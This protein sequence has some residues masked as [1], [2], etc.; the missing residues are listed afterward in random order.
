MDRCKVV[1]DNTFSFSIGH[2]EILHALHQA[3]SSARHYIFIEMYLVERGRAFQWVYALLEEASNR[4]VQIF[5]LLDDF[6]SRAV[7]R[8]LFLSHALPANI[9]V[10]AY[11]PINYRRWTRNFHRDHR[12]LVLVDGEV[13]LVGGF[14]I[15]DDFFP[16]TP[17]PGE[18]LSEK[19]IESDD[20]EAKTAWLDVA[21][22]ISGPVLADWDR[23]FRE[24]WRES[25][26]IIL[27]LGRAAVKGGEMAGRA[28]FGWGWRKQDIVRELLRR[29]KRSH[30]SL[31][32]I[33][34]Y[35]VTSWRVRRAL[36][37]AA[38]QGVKVQIIVPG[39]TSDHPGVTYAARRH[40]RS[41]LRAGV[42]LFEYQPTFIHAKVYVCDDWCSVGSFNLD[43]WT[44]RWNLEA[45]QE[46]WNAEFTTQV[47]GFF[48]QCRRKSRAVTLASLNKMGWYSRLMVYLMGKL[49]ELLIRFLR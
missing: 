4:G 33:T 29:I 19:A 9:H 25:S 15:T 45:N 21:V 40:Y 24:I 18:P 8:D 43:H 14:G 17:D 2:I 46:V 7:L 12:K 26:E 11:N 48:E 36:R 3:L 10:T 30:G 47:A 27:P 20:Q 28:A 42:E 44:Y 13:A 35:F 49:D 41:L 16:Q 34:P 6:G 37:W 5:L 22:T 32:I 1:G 31:Q 39:L 23:G 38:R